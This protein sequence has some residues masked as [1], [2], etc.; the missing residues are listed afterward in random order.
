MTQ[1]PKRPSVNDYLRPLVIEAVRPALRTGGETERQVGEAIVSLLQRP[2]VRR[3][4]RSYSPQERT[5][6]LLREIPKILGELGPL[7]PSEFLM[8]RRQVVEGDIAPEAVTTMLDAA[9]QDVVGAADGVLRVASSDGQPPNQEELAEWFRDCDPETLAETE[10]RLENLWGLDPGR[11]RVIAWAFGGL[12]TW[13]DGVEFHAPAADLLAEAKAADRP[14]PLAALLKAW[15]NRPVEVQ[16]NLRPDR[17]LATRLAQVDRSH[18]RAGRLL[19]LF[20]PAAH[21]RGQ[22][23]LPGFG[24]PDAKGP[25][26]PLALYGLGDPKFSRGGGRGAPLALRLFVEAVLAAPY[27]RRGGQPIAMNITLRELLARLYPGRRPSPAEYWPR[28][29]A[30]VEALDLMDARIPWE[31]P[32]TGRGDLR[33]VV[34]VGGH[35]ARPWGAGRKCSVRGRPA[36]WEW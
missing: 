18:P 15:K 36:P 33:R 6:T 26:L 27:E 24:D 25:A 31:D 29:M 34:S 35:T 17:I 10:R 19:K 23:V 2:E 9:A 28:L 21:R 7:S 5:R 4:L 14:N 32:E 16:P 20:S 12:V 1:Q 3:R 22:L 13:R 8:L 30:A 11:V